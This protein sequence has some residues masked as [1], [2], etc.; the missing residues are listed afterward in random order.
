M[1]CS[2]TEMRLREILWF[3]NSCFLFQ[4]NGLKKQIRELEAKL[5]DQEEELE[6]QAS[7]IHTLEHSKERLEM[8]A[9]HARQ[10]RQKEADAKDEEL[11]EMRS[12]YHK[13]VWMRKNSL[14]FSFFLQS[15]FFFPD[16]AVRNATR[17]R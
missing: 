8:S 17:R 9:E 10:Q 11:E 7:T 2:A 16:Q 1:V 14:T 4:V 13:K 5:K 6:D 12:S 3:L 15:I